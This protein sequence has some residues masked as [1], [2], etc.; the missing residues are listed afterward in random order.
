MTHR[1]DVVVPA[2]HTRSA[3]GVEVA[4]PQQ[5]VAAHGPTPSATP[6]PSA[7]PAASVPPVPTIPPTDTV[8]STP[9]TITGPVS[10]PVLVLLAFGAIAFVGSIRLATMR[11]RPRG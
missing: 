6:T 1:H 4:R 7:Q 8:V 9:G 3:N 2:H 10:A 11:S 5:T